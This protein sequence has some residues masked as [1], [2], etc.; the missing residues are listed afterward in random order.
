MAPLWKL[1]ATLSL[2][3]STLACGSPAAEPWIVRD[4][5][6]LAGGW[7]TALPPAVTADLAAAVAAHRF[8]GLGEGDHYVEEKYAYR[9]A[10]LRP[11]ILD[12]GV[13][14]IASEM[15]G[16]DAGRIDR[17]LATGDERWLD[18][19]VLYG[20][21]GENELE[22][23][24]LSPFRGRNKVCGGRVA[25]SERRFWRDLRALSEE[26]SARS[27]ERVH[28]FGFDFDANPGGGFQDARDALA[29]CKASPL[30]DDLRAQLTPKVGSSGLSE[31]ARIEGVHEQLGPD[32]APLAAACGSEAIDTVARALELL[33]FSYRTSMDWAATTGDQSAQGLPRYRQMFDTRE[34]HMH[35]QMQWLLGTLPPDARVVLLGHDMHLARATESLHFGPAPHD[36]PMWPSLGT[37][38]ERDARGSVYVLWLLYAQGTRLAPQPS[39]SCE[40]Q[41]T[42]RSGSLEEALALA[43][44]PFFLPLHAAPPDSVVNR[45]LPFGTPTSEGSGAIRH[46]ADALVFL[47][48]ASATGGHHD[49]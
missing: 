47:P 44:S 37:L 19:V 12:H 38:L 24:E 18:R 30:V 45:D 36:L 34:Q 32:R 22:R 10:F 5:T 35:R 49:R 15:G 16:S 17:Y 4:A 28:L 42:T 1:T 13:R 14:H 48:T 2:A 33:A 25:E 9:L 21:E 26:G 6:S 23:R 20:Y 7:Q 43:P 29:S 31:V 41:V 46:S 40:E 11:L 3:L 27:G 39:G 8:I